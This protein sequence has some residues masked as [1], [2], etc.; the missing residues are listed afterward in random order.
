[1]TDLRE[2]ELEA[3]RIL[4]EA[5]GP[6]KPAD[7][8]KDFSWEIDNGTLRSTLAGLMEKGHVS[9][10]KKGKAFFYRP[11]T[12]REKVM[13]QITGRLAN[14]FSGGSAADFITQLIKTEKLSPEEI[15]ELRRIA[16]MKIEAEANS[17][18]SKGGK[19]K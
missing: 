16:D 17:N 1:M 3:M 6:L 4:W 2:A 14:F 9:R 19:K 13:S 12:S 18:N 8:Q 7:I 15:A 11:K 5:E 10:D